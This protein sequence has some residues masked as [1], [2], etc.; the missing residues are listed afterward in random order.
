MRKFKLPCLYES[1]SSIAS[2]QTTNYVA[3]INVSIS[4]QYEDKGT[5]LDFLILA[6]RAHKTS[7]VVISFNNT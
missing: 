7:S 5:I 6:M 1:L 4:P 3:M 2:F